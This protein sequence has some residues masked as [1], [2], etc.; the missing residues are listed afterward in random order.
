MIKVNFS[1]PAQGRSVRGFTLIEL[2][3]VIAIIGILSAIAFPAYRD[4]VRKAK[5]GEAKAILLE[6]A[7]RLQSFYSTN[8]TFAGATF[9]ATTG[10]NAT[11]PKNTTGNYVMYDITLPTATATG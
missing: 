11:S 4:Y 8:D 9:T 1:R 5:R 3:I 2:M 10:L 6:N 7:Q